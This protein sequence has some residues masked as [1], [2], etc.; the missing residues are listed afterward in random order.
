LTTYDSLPSI[1]EG[2][3]G[4]LKINIINLMSL[5]RVPV[6][7]TG[8]WCFPESWDSTLAESYSRQRLVARWCHCGLAL[9]TVEEHFWQWR[10]KPYGGGLTRQQVVLIRDPSRSIVA[11]GEESVLIGRSWLGGTWLGLSVNNSVQN[12][13]RG[14]RCTESPWETDSPEWI[15]AS[16]WYNLVETRRGQR[17]IIR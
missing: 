8:L 1:P 12:P 3:N 5:S 14:Q 17:S 15:G 6:G 10:I 9:S 13:R 4:V 16:L 11:W 2:C 7:F